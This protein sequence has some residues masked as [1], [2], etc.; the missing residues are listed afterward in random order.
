MSCRHPLSWASIKLLPRDGWGLGLSRLQSTVWVFLVW[1][2]GFLHVL[3]RVHLAPDYHVNQLTQ[4][5][6]FLSLNSICIW[7]I[8]PNTAPFSPFYV[9]GLEM[10]YVHLHFPLLKKK[11]IVAVLKEV[12]NA[13]LIVNNCFIY[14]ARV[15]MWNW[16]VPRSKH[17]THSDIKAFSVLSGGQRADTSAWSNTCFSCNQPVIYCCTTDRPWDKAGTEEAGCQRIEPENL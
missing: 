16:E 2:R 14:L 13:S 3:T 8:G 17:G 4:H 6:P 11:A 15:S 9:S 12:W 1:H 10:E 5:V 7:R